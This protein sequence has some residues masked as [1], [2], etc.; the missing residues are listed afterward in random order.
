MSEVN[1]RVSWMIAVFSLASKSMQTKNL[2]LQMS[3]KN[4]ACKH[5]TCL[6]KSGHTWVEFRFSRDQPHFHVW[7]GSLFLC[8]IKLLENFLMISAAGYSRCILTAG[9]YRIQWLS[10]RDSPFHI[11]CVDRGIGS[12]SFIQRENDSCMASLNLHSHGIP[13]NASYSH[14]RVRH[15]MVVSGV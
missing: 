8:T 6:T 14:E 7:A 12:F 15:S 10:G 3:E 13:Y 11:E 5:M 2:G 9:K 1:Q 4:P